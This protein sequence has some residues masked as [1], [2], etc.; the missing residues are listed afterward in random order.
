[1]TETPQWEYSVLSFGSA[2]REPK[3]DEVEARLNELGAQGWEVVSSVMVS[4]H[5]RIIAKRPLSRST[6]RQR[7]MPG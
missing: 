3:N 1:M 5:L 4:N 6:R 2:L 7:T